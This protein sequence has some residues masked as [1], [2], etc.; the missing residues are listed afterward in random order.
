MGIES[1]YVVMVLREALTDYLYLSILRN[2][3]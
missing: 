1:L 2:A 3:H